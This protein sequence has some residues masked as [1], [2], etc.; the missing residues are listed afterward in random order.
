MKIIYS[1]IGKVTGHYY[2]DIEHGGSV[3]E[4]V[5]SGF[6]YSV[7]HEDFTVTIDETIYNEITT[8]VSEYIKLEK[9]V[10]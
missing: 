1:G 3:Y 8:F 9:L 5:A 4:V 6:G 7:A 2:I 10:R